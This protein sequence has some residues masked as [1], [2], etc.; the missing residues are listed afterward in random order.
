MVR[1]TE[2]TMEKKPDRPVL[3]DVKAE[4]S[5][6]VADLGKMVR[7][8]WKLARLEVDSSATSI[9]RLA[10]FLSIAAALG[11]S[12]IP[13]VAVAI[14]AALDDT[15]GLPSTVWLLIFALVLSF[16]GGLTGTLAWWRFRRRFTGLEETLEELREDLVWLHEWTDRD[17]A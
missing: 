12:A 7:L 1:P 16:V 4:A 11:L 14:A 5:R 9:K 17:D 3:A 15:A 8:R 6:L 13:L 10:V 2:A